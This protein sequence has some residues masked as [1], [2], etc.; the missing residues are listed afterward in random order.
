MCVI[1]TLLIVSRSISR[2]N[3]NVE[4]VNVGSSS[5]IITKLLSSHTTGTCVIVSGSPKP[6]IDIYIYLHVIPINT[7]PMQSHSKSGNLKVNVSH[8]DNASTSFVSKIIHT[9]QLAAS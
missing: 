6:C 4:K 2:D 5:K 8:V 7:H 9:S 3:T 1:L